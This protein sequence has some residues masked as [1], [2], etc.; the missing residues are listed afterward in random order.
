MIQYRF[1]SKVGCMKRVLI[2]DDDIDLL[3]LVCLIL[4]AANL[5]PK[6]IVTESELLP[7][8]ATEHFD[9]ILMDIYLG[10]TDGRQISRHLKTDDRYKEIPILLYSAGDISPASIDESLANAFLKK[11]FDMPVLINRINHLMDP[12]QV[13][14]FN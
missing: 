12:G 14:R 3:D 13:N 9:L 11:P 6:G 7:T 10:D 1:H 8:L 5:S 4:Q 2:V